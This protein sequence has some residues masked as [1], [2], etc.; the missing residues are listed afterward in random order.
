LIASTID[1]AMS[2][3]STSGRLVTVTK[4]DARNAPTTPSTSNRRAARGEISG[5]GADSK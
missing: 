5:L 3:H 4:F 1:W 2:V